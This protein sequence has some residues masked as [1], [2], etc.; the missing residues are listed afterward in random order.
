MFHWVLL[1][2]HSSSWARFLLVYI[3]KIFTQFCRKSRKLA[4]GWRRKLTTW[5]QRLESYAAFLFILLF[6]LLN[7]SASLTLLHLKDPME[8]LVASVLCLLTLLRHPSLLMVLCLLLIL[9]FP[10]R[11]FVKSA[12]SVVQ[13]VK[14][15]S[16]KAYP[17]VAATPDKPVETFLSIFNFLPCNNLSTEQSRPPPR[18]CS[19]LFRPNSSH[20][21][22]LSCVTANN[23]GIGE[24]ETGFQF[25]T[26][27]I[28]VRMSTKKR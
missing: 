13:N 20:V 1:A 15:V 11:R 28:F 16:F 5:V 19:K 18:P 12:Q 8:P 24:G 14:K 6:L 7:S 22:F 4:R 25:A 9:D 17:S 27:S 2:E 3:I 23:T 26:V 10:N 21:H